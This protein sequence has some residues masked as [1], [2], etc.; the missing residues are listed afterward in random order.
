MAYMYLFS[1]YLL[2]A[3]PKF[4]I[5]VRYILTMLEY[6]NICGFVSIER[7]S[8]WANIITKHIDAKHCESNATPINVE[9][10]G[11]STLLKSLI[12]IQTH[13]SSLQPT[14]NILLRNQKKKS[15]RS[16]CLSN[17]ILFTAN[18]CG[19]KVTKPIIKPIAFLYTTIFQ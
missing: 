8:F 5:A 3:L 10:S 1:I 15:N 12:Q 9:S 17:S 13:R 18:K 7:S 19:W 2:G 4:Y 11:F 16:A 14:T 6:D